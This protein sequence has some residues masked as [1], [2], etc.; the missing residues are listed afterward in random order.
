MGFFLCV[1]KVLSLLLKKQ[2]MGYNCIH[3]ADAGGGGG[4]KWDAFEIGFAVILIL[5]IL[6]NLGG[7]FTKSSTTTP[8]KETTVTKP[9][10][11]CGLTIA[12][13]HSL[14]RVGSF[15]TLIGSVGTCNWQ[16]QNNV[17]LYA[18]I[19]DFYG[20]PI[21][22]YTQVLITGTNGATAQFDTAI[23]LTQQPATN[24]GY[25]LLLPAVQ[26]QTPINIRIPLTFS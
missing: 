13:P 2:C 25:L 6:A 26:P 24:K 12:R 1:L 9:K 17:A 10:E 5:G 11:N 20:K 15:V 18:Q 16:T 8:K 19:T 22:A 4:A 7:G 21:S 23:E 14:E 3:M